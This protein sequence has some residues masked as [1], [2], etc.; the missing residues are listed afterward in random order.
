M[1]I[2]PAR[3]TSGSA[4]QWQCHLDRQT[5]TRSVGNR[6]HAAPVRSHYGRDDRQ[7]QA[8]PALFAG[9]RGIQPPEAVKNR[10]RLIG[11]H[12]WTGVAHLQNRGVDIPQPERELHGRTL[13]RVLGDV[14]HK[15]AQHLAQ[16]AR[17]PAHED[18]VNS[19]ASYRRF[20]T[21]GLILAARRWWC[22]RDNCYLPSRVERP[23]ILARFDHKRP[24]VDRFARR[25]APARTVPTRTVPA[26]SAS[27]RPNP[28]RD[29]VEAR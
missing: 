24:Q 29:L 17:V 26:R 2:P 9:P 13:W 15:V 25:S 6:P 10:L 7:A 5:G 28:A 21:L 14:A 18:F 8:G 12:P 22:P 23:Y 27:V 11:R 16:L 4:R 1:W 20:R 3:T 19:G